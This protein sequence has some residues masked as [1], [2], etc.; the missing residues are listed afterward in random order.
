MA[1]RFLSWR[2]FVLFVRVSV[3]FLVAPLVRVAI[4]SISPKPQWLSW[5]LN[6]S[7]FSWAVEKRRRDIILYNSVS[8]RNAN[9]AAE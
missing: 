1:Q 9:G 4:L 6:A 8:L 5:C 2:T 3:A 7:W